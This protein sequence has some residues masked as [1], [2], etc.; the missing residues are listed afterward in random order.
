[1]RL[2]SSP[3]SNKLHGW[4]ECVDSPEQEKGLQIQAGVFMYIVE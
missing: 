3:G 2:A 4:L 1:M